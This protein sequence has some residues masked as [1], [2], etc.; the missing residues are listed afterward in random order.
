MTTIN[1]QRMAEDTGLEPVT[2]AGDALAGRFLV[3]SD[4]FR[5]VVG[6]EGFEPTRLAASR[7]ERGASAIPPTAQSDKFWRRVKDSNLH[8]VRRRFSGPGR[9]QFRYNP[10]R[11]ALRAQTR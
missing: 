5:K 3:Q 7:L 1:E 2:L 10:P 6:R 8:A 9:Y 11:F 4:A